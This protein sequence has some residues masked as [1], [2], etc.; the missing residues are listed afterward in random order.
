MFGGWGKMCR[1]YMYAFWNLKV[2]KQ[3]NV[4]GNPIYHYI[5]KKQLGDVARL[6]WNSFYGKLI[7]GKGRRKS[8]KFTREE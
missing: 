3:K 8:T 5:M 2:Y 6:K 1:I 7:E 4:P